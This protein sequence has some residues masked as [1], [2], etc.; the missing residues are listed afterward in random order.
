MDTFTHSSCSTLLSTLLVTDY[1][2]LRNL[3]LGRVDL[4]VCGFGTRAGL[5]A[6]WIILLKV[7]NRC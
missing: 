6:S 2:E 3:R 5:L 4:P 7:H 1:R